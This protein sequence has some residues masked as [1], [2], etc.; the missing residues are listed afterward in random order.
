MVL[1]LVT[2]LEHIVLPVLDSIEGGQKLE[3]TMLS[4]CR[5]TRINR[6]LY[7]AASNVLKH[8][9]IIS[10]KYNGSSTTYNCLNCL[11]SCGRGAAS[12]CS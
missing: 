6:D 1:Y 4:N 12:S 7:C 9:A 5:Q 8:S 3:D 2:P 10:T 11:E